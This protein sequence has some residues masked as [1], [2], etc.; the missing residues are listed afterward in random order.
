MQGPFSHCGTKVYQSFLPQTIAVAVHTWCLSCKNISAIFLIWFEIT[1][2]LFAM[3]TIIIKKIIIIIILL[4]NT[5]G[6]SGLREE[7]NSTWQD[8][9][10]QNTKKIPGI[11]WVTINGKTESFYVEAKSHPYPYVE[12][13]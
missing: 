5:Y 8:M 9:A 11:T 3:S 6:A 1:H 12:R 7:R 4:A 13:K 10:N 2:Y